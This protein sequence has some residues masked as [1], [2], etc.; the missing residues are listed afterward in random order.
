M[1]VDHEIEKFVRMPLKS[2]SDLVLFE[3]MASKKILFSDN[4]ETQDAKIFYDAPNN[5]KKSERAFPILIIISNIAVFAIFA[6][7]IVFA[8]LYYFLTLFVLLFPCSYFLVKIYNGPGYVEKG[9]LRFDQNVFSA[10]DTKGY[11]YCGF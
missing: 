4:V 1:S 7:F 9:T 10:L 8:K 5:I 2:K 11:S 6:I 3:K